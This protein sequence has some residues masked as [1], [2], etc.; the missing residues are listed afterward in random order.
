[1]KKRVVSDW[2]QRF[3]KKLTTVHKRNIVIKSK[4]LMRKTSAALTSMK[5]RSIE[6]D[7]LC[8][9]TLDELRE[10]TLAAYGSPCK[11]TK[12]ILTLE[13]IVYD[14]ITP[15]SKGGDSSKE[16]IQ[17]ISRFANNIKG[18]L[19]EPDFLLLLEWIDKLPEAL[20]ASVSRKLAGGRY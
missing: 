4:K 5:K 10:L 2:E 14:H 19:V 3:T 12:R 8:T 7:V 20:A 6:N 18:A 9:I 16:N 1:M 13:N 15:V 17:V 11:Y